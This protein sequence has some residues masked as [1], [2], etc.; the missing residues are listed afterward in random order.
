M[1]KRK[2]EA[3]DWNSEVIASQ[4]GKH[5]SC[6]EKEYFRIKKKRNGDQIEI[7]SMKQMQTEI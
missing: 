6:R 5:G 3:I 2:Y 4:M 1:R 7:E